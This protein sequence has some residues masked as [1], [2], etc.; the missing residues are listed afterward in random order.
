MQA[1]AVFNYIWHSWNPEHSQV[2]LA[3]MRLRAWSKIPK[4]PAR[5]ETFMSGQ[6]KPSCRGKR[7]KSL[8]MHGGISTQGCTAPGVSKENHADRRCKKVDARHSLPC[9]WNIIPGKT[10][11]TGAKHRGQ[12]HPGLPCARN[13]KTKSARCKKLRPH[14]P[15]AALRLVTKKRADRSKKLSRRRG[16]RQRK[17]LSDQSRRQQRHANIPHQKR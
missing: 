15:R 12:A 5:L 11:Q 10:N 6:T 1:H 8:V 16:W 14:T 2:G 9:A 4:A 7:T 13:T 17:L 3:A